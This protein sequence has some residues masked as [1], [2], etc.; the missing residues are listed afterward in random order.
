MPRDARRH[1]LTQ[2]L[3][4]GSVRTQEE[5]ATA[6]TADAGEAATQATVSRDTAAIGAVRGPGGYSLPGG[7]TLRPPCSGPL[8]KP[9]CN[10]TSSRARL[11]GPWWCCTA[12]GHASL[13]ASKLDATPPEG[14]VGCIA[15]DDT[16]FIATPSAAAAKSLV[17]ALDAMQEGVAV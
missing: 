2:L 10:A 8:W 4:A 5:L 7:F 14:M 6:A 17:R 11:R 3:N 15:G 9:H 16:I 13:L 12:P 1:L